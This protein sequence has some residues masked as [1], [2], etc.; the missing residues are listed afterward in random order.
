MVLV[1][2]SSISFPTNMRNCEMRLFLDMKEALALA[3]ASW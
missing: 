1:L 3:L 2:G